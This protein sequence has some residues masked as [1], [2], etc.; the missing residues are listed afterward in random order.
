[1]SS[2]DHNPRDN[3]NTDIVMSDNVEDHDFGSGLLN[4]MNPTRTTCDEVMKYDDDTIAIMQLVVLYQNKY[5]RDD[6]TIANI[7]STS[8][9]GEKYTSQLKYQEDY[10]DGTLHV[11]D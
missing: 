7:Y 2:F 10:N 5:N 8:I 1:M 4:I 3:N 9:N 11:D 6:D